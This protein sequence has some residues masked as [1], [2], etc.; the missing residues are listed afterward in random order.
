MARQRAAGLKCAL[1]A[2]L[3]TGKSSP[4]CSELAAVGPSTPEPAYTFPAR[5]GPSWEGE[6]VRAGVLVEKSDR[7]ADCPGLGGGW[8]W[9]PPNRPVS[10]GLW[11]PTPRVVSTAV[12]ELYATC[13]MGAGDDRCMETSSSVTEPE[14]FLPP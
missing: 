6:G 4:F 2:I 3:S 11:V 8:L 1:L 14:P 10:P 5:L 9:A 13:C 7:H 12:P